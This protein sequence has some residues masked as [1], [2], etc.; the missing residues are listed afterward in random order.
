M[1]ESQ[2][3]QEK[4]QKWAL[5]DSVICRSRK[6]RLILSDTKQV[7]GWWPPRDKGGEGIDQW[8]HEDTYRSEG[9]KLS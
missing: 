4:S 8:G 2:K 7:G 1:D 5:Y 9:H 6:C 3:H